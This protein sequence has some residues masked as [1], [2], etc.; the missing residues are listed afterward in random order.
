M[1]KCLR[2]FCSE[3]EK[4]AEDTEELVIKDE[5]SAA[6]TDRSCNIHTPHSASQ[7]SS[8]SN[9]GSMSSCTVCS[10]SSCQRQEMAIKAE[11]S[12]INIDNNIT[13]NGLTTGN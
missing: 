13:D 1:L 4:S 11:L 10:Y 12:G 5:V 2:L 3:C 8:C 6:D 7:H 9:H